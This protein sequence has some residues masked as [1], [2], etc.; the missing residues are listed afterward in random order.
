MKRT[1]ILLT[2]IAVMAVAP[3][4]FACWKCNTTVGCYGTEIGEPGRADCWFDG[5]CHMTGLC[6]GFAAV[7]EPLA[8]TYT[9]AA[10][11]VV[12]TEIAKAPELDAKT[13]P[14]PQEIVKVV[15]ER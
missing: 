3:S 8:A 5:A 6:S 13:L 12:E 15:A 11:H 4:A 1:A 9:V 7:D 14:E 10:V 2:L